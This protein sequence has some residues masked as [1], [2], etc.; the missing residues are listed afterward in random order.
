MRPIRRGRTRFSVWLGHIGS[1]AELQFFPDTFCILFGN[2]KNW[3]PPPSNPVWNS[4]EKMPLS[5]SIGLW[6]WRW[7]SSRLRW[8]LSCLQKTWCWRLPTAKVQTDAEG[9]KTDPS[10]TPDASCGSHG[11]R[12][13]I[14]KMNRFQKFGIALQKKGDDFDWSSEECFAVYAGWN[15]TLTR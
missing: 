15:I 3:N 12:R 2:F 14:E 1:E 7:C 10:C 11:G 5:Y 9:R 4:T 8:K 6:P 13:A